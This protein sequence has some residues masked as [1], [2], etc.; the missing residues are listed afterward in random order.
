VVQLKLEA[1]PARK[2]VVQPSFATPVPTWE[3]RRW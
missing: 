3:P 2:C 1:F